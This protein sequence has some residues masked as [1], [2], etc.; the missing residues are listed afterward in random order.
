MDRM[1]R[2]RLERLGFAVVTPERVIHPHRGTLLVVAVHRE[3]TE[4]VA[5]DGGKWF[6]DGRFAM[7]KFVAEDRINAHLSTE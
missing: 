7:G 6:F 4:L 2:D 5:L 1:Q 3:R